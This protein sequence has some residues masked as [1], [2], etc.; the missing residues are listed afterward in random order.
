MSDIPTTGASHPGDHLDRLIHGHLD[1]SLTSE[2]VLELETVLRDSAAARV[3]FWELAEVDGLGRDAARLAWGEPSADEAASAKAER[4]GRLPADHGGRGDLPRSRWIAAAVAGVVLSSVSVLALIPGLVTWRRVSDATTSVP[5][6]PS[7]ATV[8]NTR[9]LLADQTDTPLAMGQP[10][11]AGRVAILGGAVELTLRNGV[12]IILEGPGEMDLQ[13]EL[14]AFLHAG[15]AVVRMPSGMSGFRLDTATT[16]VLDLG[17]EF[18]VKA[19][20]GFVTDVQVFDGAVVASSKS[21]AD[22]ARFPTRLEAGQAARFSPKDA[23]KPQPIPYAENR[24]VRRLPLDVGV[25]LPLR[26]PRGR[27]A[28]LREADLRLYG[29]PQHDAIIVSRARG[30]V[31]ID[32]RLDDWRLA[33]GFLSSRDGSDSCPEWA[34]GRMMYDD[35]HLYIAAHVGDPMPMKSAI[36]PA[37]DP[38]LGWRGGSVQVRVSTDREM[39]WPAAG[40]SASYYLQ[41]KLVPSA[42]EKSLADNPRLAHLTMW[43]HAASHTPCLT[44]QR[45]MLAGELEVNPSAGQPGGYRG[46][47]FRDADGKGYVL[48]YA[49][50]WRLLN[51]A[52]D[53]PR[54]GDVLAAVWQVYW[55]DGEGRLQRQHMVE[56]RN[57]LEPREINVWE[58]G[59]TWGRA[60]YR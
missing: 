3:R 53:H 7:L 30:P 56:I 60:E 12:V 45:G 44:I 26:S 59:A 23:E 20:A 47:F 22:N 37:V 29:R 58:R 36:D 17:T 42:E 40:N 4:R 6:G 54:S 14:A 25:P 2:G 41:R 38:D 52:D 10:V 1:D 34:D 49:I 46:A 48:E 28:D 55:S 19:A 31:T 39:G 13:G 11:V 57:L 33:P 8:T 15:S 24:F 5:S 35:E 9:F 27:E 18:A 16:G 21:A 51:C 43:Y 50:P 32:G